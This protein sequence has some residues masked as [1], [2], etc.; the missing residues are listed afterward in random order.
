[1]TRNVVK[2]DGSI[3]PFDRDR[4]VQAVYKAMKGTQWGADEANSV[5][6]RVCSRLATEEGA[7]TVEHIQDQVEY[8]LMKAFPDIARAYILYR[9]SRTRARE[10]KS[11]LFGEFRDILTA[12]ANDVDL[13]RE[14]ANIA[15]GTPMGRMLRIGSESSKKFYMDELVSP[16]I[17]EAHRSGY[18][19]CHD[20]DFYASTVNCLQIPVGKL[21][22]SGFFTGHGSIRTPKDIRTAA[23]LTCIIIQ[24]SQNDHFGGQSV[25]MFEYDLAPYVH[26]TFIKYFKEQVRETSI[27]K[28]AGEK[29]TDL[30]LE[31]IKKKDH[32]GPAVFYSPEQ[33]EHVLDGVWSKDN[34]DMRDYTADRVIGRYNPHIGMDFTKFLGKGYDYQIPYVK[35]AYEVA[36]RLT[37][38]DTFQAME[39]LIHNL[40]TM[41]SRAGAQ[42][43]FS[44]L[45]Y[46]TGTTPEQRM[47]IEEL[48][49]ATWNGLGAG[50]TPIFPVQVFKLKSGVNYNPG[51]PNYDLFKLAMKVSAKRMFPNFNNLDSKQNIA[52]YEAG[53]PD[54][55]VAT[56]GCVAG[57]EAVTYRINDKVYVDS[58][59]NFYQQAIDMLWKLYDAKYPVDEG[60]RLTTLPGGVCM[61]T[62]K[63]GIEVWDSKS[64][65]FVKVKKIIAN[66]DKGDWYN[67]Y[68]DNMQVLKLTGDHPLPVDGKGRT[69]VCNMQA[70]DQVEL[71][72]K[73]TEQGKFEKKFAT[74]TNIEWIPE[75]HENSYD[76]ETATDTFDV[77]GVCSHNCRT[78]VMAN[79]NGPSTTSGRG[80]L[81]FTTI[82]LPRL[83]IES[84]GNVDTF[85]GKLRFYLDLIVRQ[86]LERYH[87]QCRVKVRNLPFMA[88]QNLYMGM[89]ELGPDDSIEE[90]IKNGTLTIG[91][92]GLAECLKSLV[93]KHHGESEEAQALGLRIVGEI[94]KTTDEATKKYHLNFS[95]IASPAEGLSGRFV[96]IDREKYGVIPGVTDREYY[97]NSNHVPV[98]YNISAFDKIRIEAPY[99]DLCNGGNITYIEYDGDPLMNLEA[100]ETLV[101]RMHDADCSY[102]AINHACDRDPLCGYVGVIGDVCPRC[103]RKEGEAVSEEKMAELLKKYP[104]A[105]KIYK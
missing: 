62:E 48:L 71:G 13:M 55:E 10:A 99:H 102:F 23:A 25:P 94:R 92:I 73:V 80:N 82:N 9:E 63:A 76:V 30:Y 20:A 88:G 86:L 77:S 105:G 78:R 31:E 39:A 18:I 3:V 90:A 97:T 54:T 65:S 87:L 14:N 17:A 81:S 24:S 22:D 69:F 52:Y 96:K 70:G 75:Y 28:M 59:E 35:A 38:R 50:E 98:Y 83:A 85:F 95:V 4:I 8:A 32:E 5:A 21:L 68:L 84:A 40:N 93:G 67:V 12:E 64:D 79:C 49:H 45:N 1:M 2:R 58:F 91:Y 16:D 41:A 74:V 101:R 44:S 103:G 53:K 19:H 36:Y 66:L 11:K 42:V 89:E 6:D 72:H 57:D 60:I 43:P 29:G 100:F 56:M 7:L 37:K 27:Y 15:G 104:E 51:D 34:M 47:I 33:I 46:G 61:D 26:K